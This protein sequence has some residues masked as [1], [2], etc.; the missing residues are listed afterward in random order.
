MEVN[1]S[2]TMMMER[3]DDVGQERELTID[4][5]DHMVDFVLHGYTVIL[6]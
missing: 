2:L 4:M 3:L 6:R 5:N 1:Q